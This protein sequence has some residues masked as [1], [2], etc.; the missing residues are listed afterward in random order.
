LIGL[1][2]EVTNLSLALGLVS[3]FWVFIAARAH[4]VRPTK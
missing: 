2:A 3:V 1:V 4:I